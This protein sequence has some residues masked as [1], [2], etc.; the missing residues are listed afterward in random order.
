M[1]FRFSLLFFHKFCT[2]TDSEDNYLDHTKLNS[3]N[4]NYICVVILLKY[5]FFDSEEFLF[6]HVITGELQHRNLSL[7]EQNKS[8]NQQVQQQNVNLQQLQEL[9]NM[10]Q[11]SHRYWQLYRNLLCWADFLTTSPNGL[12]KDTLLQRGLSLLPWLL[13]VGRFP[14]HPPSHFFHLPPRE[15]L[16]RKKLVTDTLAIVFIQWKLDIMKG[17]GLAKY[18]CYETRFP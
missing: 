7:Q 9:T 16:Q 8:L 14:V 6:C 13:A 5:A 1:S 4:D 12:H 10:L 3:S 15:P 11:E 2:Q 18:V 17:K